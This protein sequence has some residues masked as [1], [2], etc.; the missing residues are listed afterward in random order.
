MKVEDSVETI[1]E[2]QVPDKISITTNLDPKLPQF[3]FDP[4]MIRLAIQ[5][6]IINAFQAMSEGGT[7]TIKSIYS[8]NK[9]EF[10]IQDT[11]TGIQ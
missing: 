4:D 11:G 7:L 10:V 9:A 3:L 8:E 2:L 6:L 1:S 5:N